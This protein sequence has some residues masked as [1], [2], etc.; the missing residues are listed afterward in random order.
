VVVF[1]LS[2]PCGKQFL[3]AKD[4]NTKIIQEL[5]EQI[6]DLLQANKELRV[7]MRDYEICV[8]T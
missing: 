8:K 3:I 5:G 4:D 7:E 2:L 1:L 6:N